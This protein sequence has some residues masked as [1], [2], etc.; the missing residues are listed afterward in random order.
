MCIAEVEINGWQYVL[1]NACHETAEWVPKCHGK[2]QMPS[3]IQLIRTYF[4]VWMSRLKM[5]KYIYHDAIV[6]AWLG[7]MMSETNLTYI[8]YIYKG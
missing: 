1:A 3:F 6:Y 7:W 5:K 4:L 2:R 8:S